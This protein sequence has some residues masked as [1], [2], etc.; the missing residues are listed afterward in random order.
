MKKTVHIISHSHWDR[1]WY[2]P[3]EQHHM[4]LI[5]LFDDL[6]EVFENDP[7]YKSYHLDGQ[8]ISLDDYLEVRPENR[9][10]LEKLVRDKKLFIGPFYILQDDFLISAEANAR[11]ML[12]GLDESYKWGEP[13]K[14][15]YFPDTFGNMGQAPQMMIQGNMDAVAYGR[16]VKTTGFNNVVVDEDYTSKY[17]EINWEG[18]DGTEIFSILFANWYSNGNEIPAEREAAISF[19]DKKLADAERYASTPHLLMMNGVDHQPIQKDVAKAIALANEL[20]PDYE[21]IHSNF[22][23]YI[24]AVKATLPED[25]GTVKGELTSQETDGWYT[26]ANTSSSRIYLKQEN[27]AVQNL[28]ERITEPLATIATDVTGHYPHEMLRYA[29]KKLMQNHPH[30]SICGCGVDSIHRGMMTRFEDAK[31]VGNFVRDEA[32]RHIETA[33]NTDVFPKASRP[34]VVF[35]TEGQEKS[36]LV[37]V[38]VEWERIPFNDRKP[39]ENYYELVEKGTP[40]VL[41][42]NESGKSVPFEIVSSDVKYNYDLPKDAFRKPHFARYITVRLNMKMMPSFSWETFALVEGTSKPLVSSYKGLENASLRVS[43]SNTGQI[44]IED[45]IHGHTYEDVL[46]FDDAGDIG[47]EYIFKQSHDGT[48]I[49]SK[50]LEATVTMLDD[51]AL[52]KRVKMTQT[53]MIPEAAEDLLKIEQESVT[54]MRER[55]S[56]RSTKLIPLTLETIM[57]LEA[58]SPILKFETHFNNQAKD[59][60]VR[61][62]FNSSMS[63]PTHESESIYEV[64]TRPNAVSKSWQNP[65]NPQHQQ[66][67]SAITTEEKGMI[68]GNTG[69]HEYEVLDNQ[70]LAV[71]IH[72]GTGEMGDW[73]YFPTPEAQV[74]GETTVSYAVSFHGRDD[75]HDYYRAM[76]GIQVPFITTQATVHAGPFPSKHQYLIVDAPDAYVTSLKRKERETDIMVRMFNLSNDYATTIHVDFEGTQ[77]YDSSLIEIVTDKP[78]DTTLKA[79]EIRTIRIPDVK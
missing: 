14:L 58:D 28:L 30:D 45:K 72:R 16:G 38:E 48:F 68:V 22:P 23:D 34:F 35:N 36:G 46:Y 10:K 73:G 4:R 74:L 55:L 65:T 64:V 2:M 9:E 1:E 44:D 57:T 12:V 56:K 47:N 20:Y 60:R 78:Y 49:T 63:V 29:W 70:Y 42:I 7:G 75:K 19:W 5:E 52:V 24:E 79:A 67:F 62:I 39:Q 15:G 32:L 37:E 13:V 33:L 17:S 40:D 76:K 26:L 8:T 51:T 43:I 18:A 71:T 59:H 53:M 31:Q 41:V 25:I 11:N 77:L 3:Y 69:L 21:F 66:A 50:G 6:F 61:A 54:E 27:V